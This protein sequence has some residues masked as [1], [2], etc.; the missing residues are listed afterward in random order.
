[1]I[2]ELYMKIIM[3]SKYLNF[4]LQ[5]FKI[6]N[7]FCEELVSIYCLHD[8]WYVQLNFIFNLKEKKKYFQKAYKFFDPFMM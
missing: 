1:M 7:F 8:L 6:D 4:G 3:L 2:K 5:R